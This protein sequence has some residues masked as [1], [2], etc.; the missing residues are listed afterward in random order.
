MKSKMYITYVKNSFIQMEMKMRMIIK[1]MRMMK[2]RMIKTK[3]TEKLK[4]IVI[5]PENLGELLITI[6]I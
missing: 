3:S 4:I 6:A 5:T 1:K 2:M